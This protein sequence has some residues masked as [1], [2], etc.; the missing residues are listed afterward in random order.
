MSFRHK[1]H[2][3]LPQTAAE[4]C[5][6]PSP[7]AASMPFTTPAQRHVKHY[8]SRG[9]PFGI[10][11]TSRQTSPKRLYANVAHMLAVP[12]ALGGLGGD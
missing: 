9:A 10:A 5:L 6:R 3:N 1:A 2:R 8:T 12:G 11:R 4:P 7:G